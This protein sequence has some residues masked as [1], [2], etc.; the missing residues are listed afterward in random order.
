MDVEA[1]TQI[2]VE[3]PLKEKNEISQEDRAGVL[4]EAE[5]YSVGLYE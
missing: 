2:L 1:A 3:N 5:H 4:N